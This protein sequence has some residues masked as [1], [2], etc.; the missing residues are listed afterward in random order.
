[1]DPEMAV[2]SESHQ[3]LKPFAHTAGGPK[4]GSKLSSW[5]GCV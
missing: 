3:L 4:F 1:M 5:L 2:A